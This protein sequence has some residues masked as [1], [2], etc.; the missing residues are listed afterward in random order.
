[1]GNLGGCRLGQLNWALGLFHTAPSPRFSQATRL[2]PPPAAAAPLTMAAQV[3][4]RE[5]EE[6]VLLGNSGGRWPHPAAWRAPP[7]GL[8][9]FIIDR[10]A[11]EKPP[12]NFRGDRQPNMA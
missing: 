3:A 1:M 11:T 4:G 9:K 12:P 6:G 5:D 2:T 10:W 7:L 8:S